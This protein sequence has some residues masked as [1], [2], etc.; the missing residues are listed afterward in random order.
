LHYLDPYYVVTIEGVQITYKYVIAFMD[1]YSRYIIHWE[2]LTEKTA[3]AA[4]VALQ[5]LLVKLPD[6]TFGCFRTDNGSEFKGVFLRTL[7]NG[8]ITPFLTEPYSPWQN[9]KIEN[10]WKAWENCVMKRYYNAD[11][12]L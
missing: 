8:D 1:D 6:N 10:H 3:A 4:N 7:I 11:W 5:H 12:Y 2:F 9:G